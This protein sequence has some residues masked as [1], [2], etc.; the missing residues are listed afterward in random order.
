MSASSTHRENSKFSLGVIAA[1]L[2]CAAAF[3]GI[4]APAASAAPAATTAWVYQSSFGGALTGFTLE[5]GSG[6]ILASVEF[7]PEVRV[8]APDPLLGG[9]PLTQFSTPGVVANLTSDRETGAVYLNENDFEGVARRYLSDGAPTPTYTLDPDFVTEGSNGAGKLT[10]DPTTNDLL[11]LGGGV[12]RRLDPETGELISSFSVASQTA[13]FLIAAGLD[14]TIYI[15]GE[16]NEIRRYTSTGTLLPKFPLPGRSDGI[17]ID[18]ETGNIVAVVGGRVLSFTSSGEK[19]FDVPLQTPGSGV[20]VDPERDRLYTRDASTGNID[21]YVPAPYAG[22]EPPVASAIT[23]SGF[24][25]STEVD[26]GEKEGGGVPD[27]SKVHFEYRLVGEE[28]W[29]T[30]PDQEVTAPGSF[31]ADITGL[32]PNLTY[33]VRAVASNSLTAH[34]TDPVK[35]TTAPVPPVTETSN[36]T[37]V[38]ETSAVLNGKV[39]PV[40]LLTTYH[41]EY[42]VTTEYGSRIPVVIEATAGNGYLSRSFSRTITGL[43][44]GTTYHFRLVATNS[45]GTTEGLDQTFTTVGAGGISVRGFEQVTPAD[46]HGVLIV[47]GLGMQA[48]ENGDGFSYTTKEGANAS[49]AFTRMV[50]TRGEDDWNDWINSDPP[51]TVGSGGLL[52]AP[53]LAVSDDFTHALVVS[54]R[55]LTPGGIDQGANILLHN[56]ATGEYTLIA[57]SSA[58]GAFN[59]FVGIGRPG[60]FLAGAPDFSWVVFNSEAPLVPEAP[61]N[62]LY[63]WSENAGL[64]LISILPNGDPTSALFGSGDAVFKPVSADGSRIYFSGVNGSEEGVF[65]LEESG[66]ATPVSVSQVPGDPTTPQP[67]VLLGVNKDGRYAFLVSEVRLTSDAPGGSPDLYRYDVSD[68]SLEYL[69]VRIQ[70]NGNGSTGS[71]GISD[72]G[73][74]FYFDEVTGGPTTLAVW[75]DGSVRTI[76]DLNLSAGGARPSPNGRYFVVDYEGALRLYDAETDELNCMSCLADGT[77]VSAISPGGNTSNQYARAVTDNGEAFFSTKGR[78][79]AADVNGTSDVYAYRD[80]SVHLISPGNGPFDALIADVSADGRDV[81]FTTSQKLVGRDDDEATDL[82]DAR[83]N[84]GLPA[85]SPPPPQECLRDDCKATPNA[86]PELPFGGSEALSGPGNVNP[87]RHRKCGKGKRAKKVKGKVRCVKKHKAN[88]NKKGGNR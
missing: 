15:S 78:L 40:G 37:D 30:T 64:E 69:G 49:S 65:L 2:V 42:G 45:A 56:L 77:P 74:T 51:L 21:T 1:M 55:A 13:K 29:V 32:S 79:V 36:A 71:L 84:G 46:K 58:P 76:A 53:T 11:V 7:T 10:V 6:N 8:F 35:V 41:F 38:T 88:K 80:G 33:E 54:N 73:N 17:T 9:T 57:A 50:S 72:D 25:L 14:G 82:Y 39:N 23:T 48:E 43:S 22:V 31:G 86:G 5:G 12:V 63:R 67:A 62:A 44:P 18:P 66:P 59:S 3:L 61:I 20:A 70:Y 4:G 19:V 27:E 26:P 75:H 34:V 28:G 68:G 87:P 24:H 85:Q 16:G 83:V 47:P 81:F 60:R 52:T